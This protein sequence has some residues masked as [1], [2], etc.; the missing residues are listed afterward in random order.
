MEKQ[1]SF[2]KIAKTIFIGGSIV[3]HGGQNP[4]EVASKIWSQHYSWTKCWKF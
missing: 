4:I 3:N 2:F 1:E